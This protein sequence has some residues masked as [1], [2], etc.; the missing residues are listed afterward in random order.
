MGQRAGR[1]REGAI[2]GLGFIEAIA[3]GALWAVANAVY[4]D[5]KRKGTRG[6]RRFV[7]FWSGTP[8][9]WGLFFLMPEGQVAD[10]KPPPDDEAALLAEI[11]RDRAKRIVSGVDGPTDRPEEAMEEGQ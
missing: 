6:F 10:I 4:F 2:M 1:G 5:M 7:A 9:T 11:R 3:V 8:T